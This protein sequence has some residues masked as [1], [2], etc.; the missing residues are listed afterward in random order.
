MRGKASLRL[1]TL[2]DALKTAQGP[3]CS[4][5]LGVDSESPVSIHNKSI[6]LFARVE[7]T[8]WANGKDPVSQSSIDAIRGARG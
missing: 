5:V 7:Q 2:V 8:T 1:L 4:F 3:L 6:R